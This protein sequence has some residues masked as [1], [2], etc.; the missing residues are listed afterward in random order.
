MVMFGRIE[1]KGDGIMDVR[2]NT[3]DDIWDGLLNAARLTRCYDRLAKYHGIG[4]WVTRMILALSAVGCLAV[5]SNWEPFTGAGTVIAVV[6]LA[7]AAVDLVTDF[8]KKRVVLGAIARDYARV[9][10]KWRQLDAGVFDLTEQE[11]RER[12]DELIE[13]HERLDD[14]ADSVGVVTYNWLNKRCGIEAYTQYVPTYNPKEL[15]A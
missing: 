2:E 15:H 10:N 6:L 9:E 4:R 13:R 12:I 8:S 5:I 14:R 11:A 7:T 1:A 3:L